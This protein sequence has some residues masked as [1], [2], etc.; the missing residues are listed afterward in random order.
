MFR[1]TFNYRSTLP[2]T[3]GCEDS[4]LGAAGVQLGISNG[5]LKATQVS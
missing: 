5:E 1:M 2:V 3:D 4:A